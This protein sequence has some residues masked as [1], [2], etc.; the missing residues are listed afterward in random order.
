MRCTKCAFRILIVRK[1]LALHDGPNIMS[2]FGVQKL[3]IGFLFVI[4][5]ALHFK[6]EWTENGWH[7]HITALGS[8]VQP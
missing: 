4:P 3:C 2:A 8:L 5:A 1:V 6:C 7:C